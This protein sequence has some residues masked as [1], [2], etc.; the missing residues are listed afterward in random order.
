MVIKSSATAIVVAALLT[1]SCGGSAPTAP[2]ENANPVPTITTLSPATVIAADLRLSGAA[3]ITVTVTGTGF[4][5][6]STVLVDGTDQAKLTT[7]DGSTQLRTVIATATVLSTQGSRTITVFNPSP[8]GGTSNG[9][10]LT[11]R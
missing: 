2:T 4:I 3:N 7:V 6:A 10:Q 11:V 5:S 1:A 9:L 8:G